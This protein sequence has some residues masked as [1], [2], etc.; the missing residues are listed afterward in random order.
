MAVT[1]YETVFITEPEISNDQVD[2]LINKIKQAVTASNGSVT[3]E[4]RWGRRRL[5]HPIQGHREG[6]YTVMTFTADTSVV[7]SLDHFF[8]IT[9]A[10]IR[11]M[12]IKV[13]KKTKKFAPR[14]E[15]PAGAA[16]GVRPGGRPGASRGRPEFTPRPGT[17]ATAP[18]AGTETAA[19]PETAAV[20][21]APSATEG[22]TS[23]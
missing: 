18:A 6:F 13:I 19:K 20:T 11:H 2:Q 8:A 17:T 10:V 23:A 9:D 1:N 22:G 5:A 12:T 7:N 14:R 21:P 4:D 3:G 16:E 15:R